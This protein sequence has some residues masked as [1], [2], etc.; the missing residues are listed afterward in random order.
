[1][2]LM[3]QK[4]FLGLLSVVWVL[5][6][7]IGNFFLGGGGGGGLILSSFEQ[8]SNYVHSC[9]SGTHGVKVTPFWAGTE[10]LISGGQCGQPL[11]NEI[12]RSH[13]TYNTTNFA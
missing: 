1:M 5:L 9:I 2:L 10:A 11:R 3:K 7:T 12:E 4:M 6:E 13:I 8:W